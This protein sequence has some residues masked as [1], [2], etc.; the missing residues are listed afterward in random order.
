MTQP[1]QVPP[2]TLSPSGIAGSLVRYGA[3]FAA[4]LALLTAGASPA[5][6]QR[7]QR[8]NLD[9]WVKI[10]DDDLP[11]KYKEWLDEHRVIVTEAELDVFLRLESDVQYDEFLKRFWLV[12][13]P[14][15]GT[16]Q[17][18]YREMYQERL[19]HVEFQFGRDTPRQGRRTDR[20]RM[21]LLLGEPLNTVSWPSTQLAYPV[22]IWWYHANPKLGIPPYFYLAFFKRKGVGEYRLYSPMVDTPLA[23][24]NPAGESYM[25]GCLRRGP[26]AWRGANSTSPISCSET[27]RPVMRLVC[28]SRT[29]PH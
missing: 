25:R 18:E 4:I 28:G 14:S 21:Y 19:E 17:N 7:P 15:P 27:M 2:A 3:T 9:E 12:R 24:L 29:G 8:A 13:D 26:T 16:P 22:E 1:S 10:D 6:A 20:G 23:L 11:E 5:A